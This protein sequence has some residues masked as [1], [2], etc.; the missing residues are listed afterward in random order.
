MRRLRG[1]QH[2]RKTACIAV[3]AEG[4]HC[5]HTPS[6]GT[7]QLYVDCRLEANSTA[8]ILHSSWARLLKLPLFEILPVTM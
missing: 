8:G 6:L 1:K 3:E 7:T 2:K 5:F 4:S